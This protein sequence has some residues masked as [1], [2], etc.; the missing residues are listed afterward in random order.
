MRRLDPRAILGAALLATSQGCTPAGEGQ[1]HKAGA[2]GPTIARDTAECRDIAQ[3]EAMRRFPY[4]ASSPALGAA[5]IGL[6]QQR[7][8]N[9]RAVAEA[10]LF[11]NCLQARGYRR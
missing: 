3:D 11:N 4:R 10:S 8:D 2:D 5:G 7:D 9:A 1:W 6:G